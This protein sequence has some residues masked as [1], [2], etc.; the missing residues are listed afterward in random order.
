M[1]TK[2][3]F[4]MFA[5]AGMLLATSCSNEDSLELSGN[6]ALVTFSIG[7]ENAMNTRAIS[8]GSGVDNL[9]TQYSIR[10]ATEWHKVTI[11]QNSLLK[12]LSI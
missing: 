10:K 1:K 4:V 11:L 9:F 3:M 12:R 8:D 2:K 5:V 6:K 7:L